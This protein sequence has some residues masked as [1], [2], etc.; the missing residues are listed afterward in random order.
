VCVCVLQHR[1]PQPEHGHAAA[2][3]S[4]SRNGPW[5][6]EDRTGLRVWCAGRWVV[7]SHTHT[8]THTHKHKYTHT[9][10]NRHTHLQ[11]PCPFTACIS[12]PLIYTHTPS[13]RQCVGG[14]WSMRKFSM[15]VCVSLVCLCLCVW[16]V[17]DRCPCVSVLL[18]DVV[19]CRGVV[20]SPSKHPHPPPVMYDS[21]EQRQSFQMGLSLWNTH[22][23]TLSQVTSGDIT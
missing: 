19:G 14:H 12:L 2:G 11:S 9:Q 6:P 13:Q 5:S 21:K 16:H 20:N 18:S 7:V 4:P 10:T 17:Q 8:H 15:C 22:T 3:G 1:T 23:H